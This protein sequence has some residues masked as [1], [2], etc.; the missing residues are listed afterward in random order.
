MDADD[1]LLSPSATLPHTLLDALNNVDDDLME[2]PPGLCAEP[3]GCDVAGSD[4]SG[5]A[6]EWSWKTSAKDFVPGTLGD[7]GAALSSSGS[8]FG[9]SHSHSGLTRSPVV[10]PSTNASSAGS[11]ALGPAAWNGTSKTGWT[12]MNP[13]ALTPMAVETDALGSPIAMEGLD[14]AE[15]LAMEGMQGFQEEEDMA[16][17][18]VQQQLWCM[19]QVKDH[20]EAEWQKERKA[21][22]DQIARFRAVLTRYSIPLEEVSSVIAYQPVEQIAMPASV[23]A[24]MLSS[25]AW[26]LDVEAN[27]FNSYLQEQVCQ[28]CK[29]LDPE[30]KAILE[31]VAAVEH[32]HLHD[33][34]LYHALPFDV[35]TLAW[36]WHG[37]S[38]EDM[39]TWKP[40]DRV[41]TPYPAAAMRLALRVF[42]KGQQFPLFKVDAARES[43]AKALTDEELIKN[44]VSNATSFMSY[45]TKL[46]ILAQDGQDGSKPDHVPGVSERL[47]ALNLNA[48]GSWQVGPKESSWDQFRMNGISFASAAGLGGQLPFLKDIFAER[49][50]SADVQELVQKQ[51]QLLVCV[52]KNRTIEPGTVTGCDSLVADM[53][54]LISCPTA[55]DL[56][57]LTSTALPRSVPACKKVITTVPGAPS[58]KCGTDVLLQLVM[59][60]DLANDLA[61]LSSEGGA[62]DSARDEGESFVRGYNGLKNTPS[63]DNVQVRSLL[64]RDPFAS[65]SGLQFAAHSSVFRDEKMMSAVAGIASDIRDTVL[66]HGDACW[67]T[68]STATSTTTTTT[69][70]VRPP[71]FRGDAHPLRTAKCAEIG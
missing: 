14:P 34:V 3:T 25:A 4:S 61:Y 8:T 20:L 58:T 27:T 67:T 70:E 11:P 15:A 30:D 1:Q 2:P 40:L 60:P 63:G 28:A 23:P 33:V 69:G 37:I 50:L 22:I 10:G 42:H 56:T 39:L 36:I 53:K 54:T 31:G 13:D 71:F 55:T 29:D 44:G 19:Q 6:G 21:M 17:F 12:G 18:Y 68:T 5:L 52:V 62:P 49:K 48:F 57:E 45:L 16:E 32:A 46:G 26:L 9:G 43:Q 64:R 59:T 41:Q 24:F 35:Y 7:A 65:G 47:L 66:G 51:L 38:N